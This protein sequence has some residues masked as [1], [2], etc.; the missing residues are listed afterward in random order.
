LLKAEVEMPLRSSKVLLVWTGTSFGS[1]MMLVGGEQ[2]YDTSPSPKNTVCVCTYHSARH[3]D[4]KL[5]P[6]IE[7]KAA[8]FVQLEDPD[9][10]VR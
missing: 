1:D 5:F 10:G 7:E 9:I 4:A 3:V 2:T 6:E 8:A